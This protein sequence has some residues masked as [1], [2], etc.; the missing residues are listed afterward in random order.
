[1][2]VAK[3]YRN[4]YPFVNNILKSTDKVLAV[5]QNIPR[6]LSNLIGF[7]EI[8][9]AENRPFFVEIPRSIGGKTEKIMMR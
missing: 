4:H 5:F 2:P 1:M 9:T 7:Q 3:V 6:I 8:V